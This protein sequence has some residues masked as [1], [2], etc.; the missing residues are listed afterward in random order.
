MTA[1][2]AWSLA[3]LAALVVGVVIGR[4][5]APSPSRPQTARAAAAPAAEA[6]PDGAENLPR[7]LWNL[8]LG[9]VV[10][11]RD[12][13]VVYRNEVAQRFAQG[14]HGPALVEAAV[15]E[16]LAEEVPDRIE[17]VLDLYGPPRRHVVVKAAPVV[18]GD[19]VTGRLVLI[20]DV[21]DQRRVDA[22]RRDFVANVSHELKT[23]AG[24]IGVLAEALRGETE[25]DVVDRLAGRL[26]DEAMRLGHLV[27]DLLALS[28]FE[29]GELVEPDEVDL[30]QVVDA[31]IDRNRSAAELRAV[32]VAA[33][34]APGPVIVVGDRRQLVS[35]VGN[36]V[37]NA[38][39]YSDPGSAVTVSVS[40]DGENALVDVADCGVGIPEVDRERIFERF[41]RVD[42]ARS[43]N[44]G[45][46]GLGLSIVRHVALNHGGEVT[47]RSAEGV[48]STFTL[49]LP[50]APP[51]PAAP[52]P[53]IRPAALT[54]TARG[55]A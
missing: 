29:S 42:P 15:N 36:L 28:R 19:V 12:G 25:P 7:A 32:T 22:V 13:T 30:A 43:R 16:L 26:Q 27:D 44:T 20:E 14:R 1:A 17:R 41:Y 53:S 52:S 48:G 55:T 33:R 10:A 37:E 23:P 50:L 34:P 6:R 47:V 9:I 45:G 38:V 24:A 11:D 51:A 2:L 46:T 4:R 39:K 8:P 54:D 18:D 49:R 3:V 40:S 35:A 31:A 21:T 5:L